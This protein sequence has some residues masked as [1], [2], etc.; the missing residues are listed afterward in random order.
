MKILLTG[1]SGFV[2]SQVWPH[3]LA[4]GH[5][6]FAL[7]RRKPAAAPAG[8]TFVEA[9]LLTPGAPAHVA[10]MV[11]PE[12]VVHLAWTVEHGKFWRDPVNLDWVAASLAL[13]RA[14][15][16]NGARRL[17]AIGTCFEYDWP[18]AGDCREDRTPLAGHTL[19]DISKN[20]LRAILEP[21]AAQEG[22]A[23]AWGR[24]FYLYGAAEHPARLVA[25]LARA[26][27]AG[28]PAKC[29]RGAARRDFMDVRDA[30]AAIAAL[31]LSNVRGPVNIGT[32]KDPA[33]ADI[34]RE[35]GAI[36]GRP[37]LIHLG[38]RPDRPDEPPRIVADVT[39]LRDEVG[40]HT[41]IDLRQGLADALAWWREQGK[42]GDAS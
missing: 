11:R 34:A 15:A 6:V 3:L 36:A 33:I 12:M 28:R 7:T 16:Q 14:A 21:W 20:S 38:A 37:D 25:D 29:G 24:L 5:E 31:A 22:L 19:Y 26:L 1:A 8:L 27:A 4:A 13:A 18:A 39:R 40:F 41:H 23:L 32:G 35:M 17:V 30:G 9:D 42:S 10:G 2:G